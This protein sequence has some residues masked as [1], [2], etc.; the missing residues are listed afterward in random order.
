MK[1]SRI[2][3]AAAA[4]ALAL[5]HAASAQTA[6]YISGA[7]ATR[8]IW[9]NAILTA[10]GNDTGNAGSSI[11]KYWSGG[12][13][14]SG[15]ATAN[16]TVLTGGT[17]GGVPVTIYTSWTGSTAGNQDVAQ[18]PPE[19]NAS[20]KVGFLDPNTQ[21]GT[22]GGGI[23]YNATL[24]PHYPQFT[25]SDT[26]QSTV[27]FH[28]HVTIT[29]PATNYVTLDEASPNSPAITG[30]KFLTNKGAPA[31]LANITTNLAR[32]LFTSPGGVSLA[33]FTG[34]NSDEG[35]T[36]YPVGRD[37]GSGA[38][39]ILLAETGIGT[40]NSSSLV[41]YT[42]TISSSNITAYPASAGGTINL[43]TFSAGNGGYS[44]FSNVLTA[45]SATSSV[46]PFVTYVTDSDAITAEGAGAHELTWNGVAYGTGKEGANLTAPT[47]I[48]EGQYTYWSYLHVYYN[49][50][51]ISASY[52]S[53]YAFANDLDNELDADKTTGAILSSDVAVGRLTDGGN[54]SF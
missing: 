34:S 40:A 51:F 33:Q 52:P 35:T 39:Y 8:A 53:A 11:V 45:L 26:F 28:G 9:N 49:K 18:N 1:T 14:S 37:I 25:L 50:A 27:P 31:S 32:L 41:Q 24:N 19:Q 10:L 7:P 5:V 44:S 54:V 2:L 38:R 23:T 46:G 48:A 20:L 36:V 42:P 47:S 16:Q 21:L 15:Y 4:V 22:P 30:Y 29:S 3:F 12:T 43:I 13:L 17:I 6:I